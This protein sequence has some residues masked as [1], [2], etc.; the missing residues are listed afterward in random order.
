M[1]GVVRARLARRA[2]AT[3][4][5]VAAGPDGVAASA[6]LRQIAP[7]TLILRAKGPLGVPEEWVD[8]TEKKRAAFERLAALVETRRTTWA[9]AQLEHR[10]TRVPMT[11]PSHGRAH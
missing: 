4:A 11:G 1:A 3:A 9:I 6:S 8:F 5:R 7:V 2:A 10:H